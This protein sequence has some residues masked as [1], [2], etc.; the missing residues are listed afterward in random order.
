MQ[1]II[2]YK[3]PGDLLEVEQKFGKTEMYITVGNNKMIV[4]HI[5][6]LGKDYHKVVCYFP[7]DKL[8][9]ESLIHYLNDML[10]KKE[11][12]AYSLLEQK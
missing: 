4:Y 6:Y 10:Q 9:R 12:K 5:K 3:H 11:I 7:T 8:H 2:F 1:S